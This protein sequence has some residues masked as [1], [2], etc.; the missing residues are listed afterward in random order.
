MYHIIEYIGKNDLQHSPYDHVRMS[1]PH[2]GDPIVFPENA[3]Y[4]FNKGHGRVDHID[5]KSGR[6]SMICEEGSAFW[7]GPNRV[8]FSGGP[9]KG[10]SIDDL[11][12]TLELKEVGF[13]NW[14]NN[15]AGGGQGVDYNIMRPVFKLK[16]PLADTVKCVDC[17]TRFVPPE[18][19]NKKCKDCTFSV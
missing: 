4:P 1:T 3:P 17:G 14:G 5:Q 15:S 10:I 12:P 2:A 9:F 19:H 11:E 16:L 6:I 18:A 7:S 13:W 8:S